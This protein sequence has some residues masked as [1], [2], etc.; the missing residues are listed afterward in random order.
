VTSARRSLRPSSLSTTAPPSISALPTLRPRTAGDGREPIDEVC[1]ASALDHDALALFT[2][3]DA[4]AVM[5]HLVQPAGPPRTDGQSWFEPKGDCE[6][7][8]NCT[9]G[10]SGL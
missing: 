7:E 4:E 10:W 8:G 5:L 2:G 1:A 9:N 3:E 6:A